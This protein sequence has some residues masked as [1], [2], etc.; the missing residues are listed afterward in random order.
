LRSW[1]NPF[2]PVTRI[3]YEMPRAGHLSL[4]VY[5]LKGQLV[6]TLI[7]ERIETSGHVMWDG[8][9]DRGRRV[10]SGVYFAEARTAG[11]VKVQKMALVK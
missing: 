8:T 10:G 6:R 9:D 1:P 4:K 7:D 5:D 2:N 11:Q 3:A